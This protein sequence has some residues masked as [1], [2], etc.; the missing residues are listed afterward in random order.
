MVEQ[1]DAHHHFWRYSAAEYSW[2]GQ[3]MEQLRRDFLVTDLKPEMAS[4]DVHGVLTVQARQTIEE[5]TW[6]LCLASQCSFVRGVVGW[7]PIASPEFPRQLEPLI[8]NRKLKGLRHVLQD[9]LDDAYML[10]PG[11]QRGISALRGT[12]L[13]YD[14]LVHE[15][16]LPTVAHLVDCHPIQIFV[17]DH[18]GKPKI[19]DREFSPWRE[20]LRELGQRPNVYCKLSGMATEADWKNWTTDDLRPYFE[21]ALECFGPGRL[22]AGSDWPVCNVA[23]SYRRWWHTL[24]ELV[25]ALSLPEQGGIL[26]GNAKRVYNLEGETK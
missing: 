26:G 7:A 21:I 1:I 2:I 19:R 6:L 12:G 3:E 13:V 11:F 15:R 10:R 23:T 5:T 16:Q 20:H 24:R 9:E 18:L 17:L 4:A 25:S 14:V 8:E 22:L